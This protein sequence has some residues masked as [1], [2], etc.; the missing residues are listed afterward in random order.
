MKK[1]DVSYAIV[2]II[3]GLVIGFLVANRVSPSGPGAAPAPAA[4]AAPQASVNSSSQQ[5]LPPGHPPVDPSQPVQAGP[6]PA[7]T[8]NA[9]VSPG[10]SSSASPASSDEEVTE[11]PSLDPLPAASREKRAEQEYKNIQMLRGLPAE[12][13]TKIMFAFKNSLGVDCTYCHVKDHFE[14]DDK[15]TK[16]LARRMIAL[17]RDANAKLGGAGRVTCFTCHRGQPR[18]PS[19]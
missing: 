10:P 13:I 6:L 18:P 17:T 12:R 2:G 3:I 19:Q 8:E 11:L 14:K 4:G 15:A 5:E 7:G 9:P 16:Q 1:E